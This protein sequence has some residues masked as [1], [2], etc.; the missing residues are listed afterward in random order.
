[1]NNNDFIPPYP[2]KNKHIST[3]VPSLFRKIKDVSYERV[4]IDTPDNDF[5]DVDFSINGSRSIHVI[6]HGLEGNS[7]KAY[8]KGLVRITGKAGI[9]AAAINLRGCSDEDNKNF[10]SY[11]SGKTEDVDTVINYITKNYNYEEIF[12][13][14]FSLGGNIVLKYAG[15][16]GKDINPAI[17]TAT[18]ISVPCDLKSVAYNFTKRSNFLYQYRF[19]SSLRK[20]ALKKSERF[21]EYRH[22]EKPIKSCRSFLDFDNLI[23]APSNGFKD[24]EEYW[25]KSSC[26]PY[27]ELIR[28]PAL[29]IN[30]QND[31]FLTD[32]CYP[33]KE[34]EKNPY[35]KLTIPKYGG[36]AG[37]VNSYKLNGELWHENFV[38]KFI[39]RNSKIYS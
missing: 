29:L 26:K 30:A 14:G 23:T 37:F 24:A 4:R 17:K 22:L 39:L 31:P 13:S 6:I 38:I 15:E 25:T 2:F 19:I 32:E 8:V 11:H 7:Q 20:K 12:L 36:H 5:L 1:M 21:P 18:G 34:A 35:F 9:D 27:I 16:K 10:Y 28:I 33:H 3:V